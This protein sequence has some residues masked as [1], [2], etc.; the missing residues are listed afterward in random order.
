M[1]KGK[2]QWSDLTSAQRK[3]AIVGGA[4]ELVL[5]VFATR[6][7]RRRPADQIRGAKALWTLSFA[8]QPVGPIAYLLVG[9][10]SAQSSA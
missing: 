6:D 4:L 7:L 8:V 2:K 1:A 9:R 10:R 5:T 3:T